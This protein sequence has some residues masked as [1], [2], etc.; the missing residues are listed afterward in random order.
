ML[1]I[2]LPF[3]KRQVNQTSPPKVDLPI[4]TKAAKAN[5]VFDQDGQVNLSKAEYLNAYTN[6]D[7]VFSC[8]SYAAD[9]ISQL[10]IRAFSNK[11]GKLTPSKNKVLLQWLDQPNPYQSMSDILYIYAQSYFLAGNAYLTFE[12]VG[13]N[14]EGWILDPSKTKVVPDAKKYLTGFIYADTIAYKDTEVLFFKNSVTNNEYYGQSYLAP[15]VDPLTIEGYGVD[16]LKAFY[17]NSLVAQGLFT[18]EY[19]LTKDQIESLRLQ[20]NSLYGQGGTE[21]FGHILAPNGLKYQSLKLTPKDALLIDILQISE[22]RIYKVFRLNP[23]LLGI[24]GKN[25]SASGTGISEL[26][27]IYVNNFIRPIMHRLVKQ[28]ETSFRRILK[29]PTLVLE[30]DYSNIPEVSNII[31]EK[32]AAIKQAISMGVMSINE[33]RETLGLEEIK[34]E[35]ASSHMLPSFLFGTEPTEIETGKPIQSSPTNQQ[36]NPK[37]SADGGSENQPKR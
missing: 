15:L 29:D 14:Y 3:T 19:P 16:D 26:K 35:L 20:F 33:A 6:A 5:K 25:N 8:V 36:S 23:M 31:D 32:I 17:A 37:E 7:L 13:S 22:E 21:R 34:G 24:S 27:K 10:K 9:T 18:S 12:K 2:K 4:E 11:G 30:C 1:N 28:W